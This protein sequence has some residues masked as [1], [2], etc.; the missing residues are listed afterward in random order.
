MANKKNVVIMAFVA[1]FIFFVLVSLIIVISKKMKKTKPIEKKVDLLE[2]LTNSEWIGSAFGQNINFIINK[3]ESYTLINPSTSI[4]SELDS[5]ILNINSKMK[6]LPDKKEYKPNE[7]GNMTMQM[8]EYDRD[9]DKGIRL[10]NFKWFRNND[11]L[12]LIKY[13]P[14]SREIDYNSGIFLASHDFIILRDTLGMGI[15]IKFFRKINTTTPTIMQTTTPTIMQTTT[16][17]TNESK[18]STSNTEL[19]MLENTKWTYNHFGMNVMLKINKLL[20]LTEYMPPEATQ[21]LMDMIVTI[22][23]IPIV[24]NPS[25]NNMGTVNLELYLSN[26]K[27]NLDNMNIIWINVDNKIILVPNLQNASDNVKQYLGLNIF[28]NNS[29]TVYLPPMDW[30][31]DTKKVLKKSLTR[32]T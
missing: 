22:T 6:I 29:G 30:D 3:F 12:V 11:Q 23:G 7:Y 17:N 18:L 1:G 25:H 13:V 4:K 26:N 27:E 5:I 8:I 24:N 20:P 32:S 31:G 16:P 15:E 21:S 28:E 10:E 14:E 19:K 9:G 2:S